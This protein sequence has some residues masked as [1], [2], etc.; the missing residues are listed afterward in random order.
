MGP[1][2][3]LSSG[4]PN[5]N[6]VPPCS[7]PPLRPGLLLR[8]T[9]PAE[10]DEACTNSVWIMPLGRRITW[11]LMDGE[12]DGENTVGGKCCGDR[13]GVEKHLLKETVFLDAVHIRNSHVVAMFFFPPN[14]QLWVFY[15]WHL[16]LI[17]FLS[18]CVTFFILWFTT[19][20]HPGSCYNVP[21]LT[22]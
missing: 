20:L 14:P 8:D 4:G 7:V 6:R 3:A 15:Q 16:V 10:R 5:R 19:A 18:C 1:K 13:D 17:L 22:E 9:A 2:L 12:R 21:V 11:A